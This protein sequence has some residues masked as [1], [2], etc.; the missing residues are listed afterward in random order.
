M[1]KLDRIAKLR[2]S[3]DTLIKNSESMNLV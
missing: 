1:Q 2:Y 3:G